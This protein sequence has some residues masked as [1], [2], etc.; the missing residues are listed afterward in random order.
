MTDEAKKV[1]DDLK[2]NE[3]IMYMLS[4]IAEIAITANATEANLSQNME[5]IWK[6]IEVNILIKDIK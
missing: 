2:T 4:K 1:I 3:L 6:R 5:N